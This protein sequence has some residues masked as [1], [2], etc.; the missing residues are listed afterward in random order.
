[1][2]FMLNLRGILGIAAIGRAVHAKEGASMQGEWLL[3]ILLY[4]LYIVPM[5][6]HQNLS[7]QIQNANPHSY[8]HQ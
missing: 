5:V 1:M 2:T 7:F 6:R 4:T 8:T 3:R